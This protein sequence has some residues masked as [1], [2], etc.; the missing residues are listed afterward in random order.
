MV[1]K[2]SRRCFAYG[3]PLEVCNMRAEAA[4]DVAVMIGRHRRL[5]G[6]LDFDA[7]V[8]RVQL[9]QSQVEPK[10]DTGE[11]RTPPV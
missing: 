11:Q 6:Y 7:A 4:K 1:G 2:N 9:M 5:V 8:D 10:V 3:K